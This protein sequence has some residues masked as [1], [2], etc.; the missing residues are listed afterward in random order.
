[1]AQLTLSSLCIPRDATFSRHRAETVAEI[2]DLANLN[3]KSF[4]DETYITEG[5]ATLLRQVFQRLTGESDQG[6]YRLKQAMGGGKTHNLLAA[7]LLARDAGL[8]TTVL[9]TLR[10]KVRQAAAR[11]SRRSYPVR[12]GTGRSS[13]L[14]SNMSGLVTLSLSGSSTG[15]PDL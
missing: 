6:V 13:K 4:F 10:M 11:S 2:G 1:M 3:A 5:M 8:R 12:T 7:A 15:S 9:S 14:H